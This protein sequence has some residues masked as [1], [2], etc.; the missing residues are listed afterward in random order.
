MS[1]R[2]A[3]NEHEAW[4]AVVQ[5]SQAL[6]SEIPA[7]ALVSKSAFRDY[8]TCGVHR[9]VAFAP[10]VFEISAKARAD[11]FDFMHGKAH[12]DMEGGGFDHF[13]AA[14]RSDSASNV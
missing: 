12:F 5:E 4:R 1:F 2:R 14:F 8:V 7:A 6:L 11:L 13:N 10:S 3:S 9:D